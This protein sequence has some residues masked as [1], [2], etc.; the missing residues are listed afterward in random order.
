MLPV[1]AAAK[2]STPFLMYYFIFVKGFLLRI[3]RLRAM[4]F[5]PNGPVPSR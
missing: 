5:G 1:S 4:S 3:V 2:N